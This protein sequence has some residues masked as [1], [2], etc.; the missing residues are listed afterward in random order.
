MPNNFFTKGNLSK[1]AL[2]LLVER[3]TYI[4][5]SVS[6]EC[7]PTFNLLV[8]LIC[9]QIC[10]IGLS[11]ESRKFSLSLARKSELGRRCTFS[12]LF[13]FLGFHRFFF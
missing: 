13:R 8:K 5:H 12:T 10:S 9:I 11:S 2:F 6:I 1:M 3:K 4:G 7:L